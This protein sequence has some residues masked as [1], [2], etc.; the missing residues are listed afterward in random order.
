[1]TLCN[2]QIPKFDSSFGTN[3]FVQTDISKYNDAAQVIALQPDGKIL[4]GGHIS[5]ESGSF[6]MAIARYNAN[7]TLDKSFSIDGIDT[8]IIG[9]VNSFNTLDMIVSIQVQTDGKIVAAARTNDYDA[10]FQ[11]I[12][13]VVLVRYNAD[14]TRD[15]S[16]GNN[17]LVFGDVKNS[18]PSTIVLQPDGKIVLAGTRTV[19]Q[20]AQPQMYIQMII[21]RFNTDGS[22]DDSFGTQGTVVINP[23]SDKLISFRPTTLIIQPDGKILSYAIYWDAG[24]Q[25][26]KT[27]IIRCN[28]NGSLDN[29][30][31][32]KGFNISSYYTSGSCHAMSLQ[33]DGKIVVVGYTNSPPEYINKLVLARYKSDGSADPA[34]GTNG[35][36]YFHFDTTAV[37]KGTVNGGVLALQKDGKIIVRG[38]GYSDSLSKSLLFRYN[39]DGSLDST[40]GVNGVTFYN[41]KLGESNVIPAGD[42]ILQPDGKLLTGASIFGQSSSYFSMA[43]LIMSLNTGVIDAEPGTSN[44]LFYPNPVSN[45]STL[46]YELLNTE[47]VNIIIYDMTGKIINVPVKNESRQLGKNIETI[48]FSSLS[49]GSYILTIQTGKGN[50]NI[51]I[52]K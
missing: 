17:G 22:V 3:G 29:T 1:V 2:G 37:L 23:G 26:G 15:N 39:T 47:T 14:G 40:F 20:T 33:E 30:F 32:N 16:F 6:G 44:L 35:I 18:E 8:F 43:R 36:T 12:S 11:V 13:K 21:S 48:D 34:F 10:S 51:K 45:I 19:K 28:A 50:T 25:I 5:H 27:G 9:D 7:G 24:K 4:L 49:A 41:Y 31:G 46:Q 52:I 38:A 42:M